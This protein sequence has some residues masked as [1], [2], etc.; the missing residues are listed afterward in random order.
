MSKQCRKFER[1]ASDDLINKLQQDHLWKCL[2]PD[3]TRSPGRGANSQRVFPAIRKDRIDFYHRGGKLFSFDKNGFRTNL[4]YAVSVAGAGRPSGVIRESELGTLSP[5]S[6]FEGGYNSIKDLCCMYAGDEAKGVS[7]LYGRHSFAMKDSHPRVVVLDI[8]ASFDA[9][10]RD[11]ADNN[12]DCQDRIDL[13]FLDI[14]DRALLFVEAKRH[15]NQAIRASAGSQPSVVEQIQRYKKQLATQR[16]NV[17]SAYQHCVQN[18]N[19]LLGLSLPIPKQVLPDVPLLIFGFNR[20]QRDRVRK[21]EA[22]LERHN[23][24]CLDIGSLCNATGHTLAKWFGKA[25][26]NTS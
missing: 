3:I 15:E 26:R 2:R 4:K 19:D 8:E 22:V 11:E 7:E 12:Q 6:S 24:L 1:R 13:V 16:V 9:H 14:K 5:I 25:T 18:M 17:L 20:D 23:V 21:C 10:N